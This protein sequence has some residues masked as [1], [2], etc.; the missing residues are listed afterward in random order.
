MGIRRWNLDEKI[1]C[2]ECKTNSAFYKK[3][4]LCIQCYQRHYECGEIEPL[5]PMPKLKKLRRGNLSS[6]EI[7]DELTNQYSYF[8]D[9]KAE[10]LFARLNTHCIYHP[11]K[12][13]LDK[14]KFYSPDFYNPHS[15]TFIEIIGSRQRYSQLKCNIEEFKK[16]FPK[17]KFSVL[18][19]DGKPY[20]VN[21]KRK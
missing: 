21:E 16:M 3:R 19:G 4:Q 14:G 18:C 20:R 10:I 6:Y 17:L 9:S 15:N 2:V 8:F 13:Y 1:L 12:F 7:P 11:C 5:P